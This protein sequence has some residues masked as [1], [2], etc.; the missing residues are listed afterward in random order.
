MISDKDAEKFGEISLDR[1]S[2]GKP[3]RKR[4]TSDINSPIITM[5]GM[6]AWV[7]T[8]IAFSIIIALALAPLITRI[9]H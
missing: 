4:T 7:A 2:T 6:A 3:K 1:I 9:T 5:P 8:I